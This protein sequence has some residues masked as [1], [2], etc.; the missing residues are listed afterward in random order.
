MDIETFARAE[1]AAHGKRVVY[2]NGIWWERVRPFYSWPLNF[3]K[4]YPRGT[5]RPPFLSRAIGYA[6]VV[7]TEA[8]ANAQFIRMQKGA[9]V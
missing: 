3:L 5:V 6:H 8:E 4:A 7:P 9:T 2:H 1:V